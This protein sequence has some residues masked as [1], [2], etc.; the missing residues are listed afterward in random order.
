MVYI[1]SN[2][3]IYFLLSLIMSMNVVSAFDGLPA[4]ST[5]STTWASSQYLTET[6]NLPPISLSY[7][8]L[9][10][11]VHVSVSSPTIRLRFSNRLGESNL[12]I[13]SVSIANSVAQGSG[14]IN[15]L[16]LTQVTFDRKTSVIIPPYS[17]IYSDPFY[18]PLKTQ[19]EVAVSI[20]FGDMPTKLTSHAGSRTFSFIEEGYKINEI[21]FTDKF[22]TAHWYVLSAIEVSSYPTKKAVIC[23]GDSITDG[24][25]STDDKQNR[26]TDVFSKKLYFNDKTMNVAVVN[27]GIGATFVLG[28]GQERFKRDVIDIKGSTYIIVLYGVNDIIFNNASSIEIINGYKILIETAHKFNKFIYGCT[29]LPFSKSTSFWSEDKEK[30]RKEVNEW[31]RTVGSDKGG[32]D[33]YFD[34]DKVVKDPN[35]ET[36]L[37][38]EYDS[39]D[40]LHPSPQGYVKMVE[41]IDDLNLFTLTPNFVEKGL[42][43]VDKIGI[44]FKI[45]GSIKK[46][47]NVLV[48]VRGSCE[49]SDG[50][51][52]LTNDDEGNKTS[53]YFY[54]GV[55]EKGDFEFEIIFKVT[56]DSNYIVIRR[57]ISTMNIDKITLNAV[58]IESE[59]GEQQFSPSKDGVFI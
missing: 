29:I 23:Y 43:I 33:S 40:G 5:Y 9:R 54:T 18:Y 44:K 58:E 31:I 17:E 16:T 48:R 7:N 37:A 12:E 28:E 56:E 25:G 4:E 59:S 49:G 10:Q 22:K 14:E 27:A 35:D 26:W 3:K 19:S 36:K 55:I 32:F 45:N 34:M 38:D 30:V 51:R 13:K 46:G 20:Y 47:Q 21:K 24:R 52:I 53:D 39:G 8:S 6:N 11:I 41:A 1:K 50:F 42:D 57:P 2:I 15:P